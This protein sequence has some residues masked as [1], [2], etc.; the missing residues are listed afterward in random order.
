MNMESTNA[1]T[2]DCNYSA[3]Q[4]HYKNKHPGIVYNLSIANN[5]ETHTARH[6]VVEKRG[7]P[8]HPESEFYL[9]LNDTWSPLSGSLLE[10]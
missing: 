10:F 1:K 3:M 4:R 5:T 6:P 8:A 2:G 9:S 7:V